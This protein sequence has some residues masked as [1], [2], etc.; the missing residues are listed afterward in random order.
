M[1]F[2]LKLV[3]SRGSM[4][5]VPHIP[6]VLFVW[7]PLFPWFYALTVIFSQVSYSQFPIFPLPRALCFYVPIAPCSQSPMFPDRCA[8]GL[9][10]RRRCPHHHKLQMLIFWYFYSRNNLWS[11]IM[12]MLLSNSCRTYSKENRELGNPFTVSPG[13][14][15]CVG[16]RLESMEGLWM[17]Q[18]A[19]RISTKELQASWLSSE[20][21]CRLFR[22]G[23]FIG[24]FDRTHSF[25]RTPGLPWR[26]AWLAGSLRIN[27]TTH[28]WNDSKLYRTES[29]RVLNVCFIQPIVNLTANHWASDCLL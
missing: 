6:K 11:P 27:T 14:L 29:V 7:S 4:V 28:H 1:S 23:C 3:Y 8:W 15:K 26:P 20:F 24:S 17:F 10:N 12:D 5:L 18:W 2:T 16:V 9:L 21:F 13:V 19:E 25:S 22:S